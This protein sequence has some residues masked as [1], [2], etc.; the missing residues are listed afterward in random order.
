MHIGGLLTRHARYRPDHTAVIVGDSRLTYRQFNARVNR[1]AHALLD[2][3][4]RKGDK[5]ATL[6]PNCLELLDVYWAAAKTGLVVVPMSTLLRGQGLASLLRDSD[7]AAVVTSTVHAP[8]FDA[9]RG[10]LSIAPDRC[11]IIDAPDLPGYR[12]YQAL[13]ATMPD[14]D[15]QHIE[16]SRDDPYNIMYSSG[17]TGLPKGIVLTHGVRAGYGTIFASS[18]RIVPESIILH[19]GALVFNGAFLTFMPAFYLG[20]TYILMKAFDAGQLIATAAREQV[21]HIKLVPSQIVALLNE[22]EFNAQ[23]LPSIEMLG[24]VGAPLHLEHKLELERRFPNRLYELYGLTEGLMTI[25]DKYHRGEKLGSVGVPPPFMEIKI[26][27]DQGNEL[28]SGAVGEI[29]GR[30]PLMMTGYYGRPDLTEQTIVNGWLHS[31]DVGYVDADGFLYLVDRKKDLIISGGI[32]VFP[33]DIEEIIVQH[34][35]VREVAVFGVPSEKWGE[36]PLA[37]VVLKEPGLASAEEILQWTNARVEA[38]YQKVSQVVIMEDFP[39]SAAGKTLKRV[40]R[41]AYWQGRESKI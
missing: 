9:V 37:A 18:Y 35:A 25:L 12:D 39:R 33:R 29:C 16:L 7:T 3:G 28:P 1:V 40:M 41:D 23:N 17:T 2:L 5:I 14:T 11:L 8:V 26:I 15:P 21:T 4:L 6:L 34:P 24:S 30:G 13:I 10:E 27:D 36:T 20:T 22:P 31:G 38:G 19:A 32:N